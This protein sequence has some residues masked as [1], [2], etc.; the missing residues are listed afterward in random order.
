MERREHGAPARFG[1]LLRQH[2]RA[3]GWTQAALAE[4]SGVSVEAIS[5]QERGR[6]TPRFSTA[7]ALADTLG[8][9]P[10][11]RATFEAAAELPAD[12]E[13]VDVGPART[14]NLP[15][16]STSF[17]G[18]EGEGAEVR[19]LLERHR[20]VTLTGAGGVGK[21]R[22]AL[23]VARGLTG[24][25]PFPDGVW[26][27][28]LAP[29]GDPDLVPQVVA[30]AAGAA[31]DPG[32]PP[33]AALADALRYRRLLLVLDNCEH[34]VEAGAQIVE[35]LLGECPH[36]RLLATSRET[37]GCAGEAVFR[38]PSL[39]LPAAGGAPS[40]EALLDSAAVRLFVDRATAATTS[41]ALTARNAAA[42][43]E[44]CR[45]LDG[46]PLALE[47]AAALV[48]GLPVEE[49]A[50]RLDDRFRLLTGGRRTALG[51]QQTLRALVDWSYDLLAPPEQRLFARLSV[52][53]GA[54]TLEAAEAVCGES[55][56]EEGT[57]SGVL[58]LLLRLV[59]TSFVL[60]DDGSGRAP[61]PDGVARYR[62]LETLREYGRE[63]LV[64]DPAA[65]TSLRDRHLGYHV[66]LVEAAADEP[67]GERQ[68]RALRRL[69]TERDD[70]WAALGW[71]RDRE[72]T[73]VDRR[74]G[75]ALARLTDRLAAPAVSGTLTPLLFELRRLG[76]S[77]YAAVERR[78]LELADTAVLAAGAVLYWVIGDWPAE[79]AVA[80]RLQEIKEARGN[81]GQDAL[82]VARSRL[83]SAR[84]LVFQSSL[85]EALH[86][87]DELSG[88]AIAHGDLELQLDVLLER[89]YTHWHTGDCAAGRQAHA[90]ALTL[91]EHLRP[92][93]HTAVYRAKRMAA[94]RGS[95]LIEHNADANAACRAIHAEALALAREA[96]DGPEET[97]ARLNVADAEW[98]CH[99]YGRALRAYDEALAAPTTAYYLR[100][101]AA[102]VLGRGVVLGSMG[103]YAEATRFLSD[104]LTV[105]R[106]LGDVWFVAYGLVYL[107]TA[108]AGHGDLGAALD[109]TREAATMAERHAVGYPLALAHAHLQWLEEICTPGGA[110]HA[111]RIEAAA[112]EAIRLGLRGPAMH[113]AWV[114]LLHRTFDPAVPDHI[115]QGELVETLRT[116]ALRPPIKGMWELLGLDAIGALA[117]R[118]PSVDRTALV[119]LVEEEIGA[120]AASL[121]ADD[122]RVYL[123]TRR[124]WEVLR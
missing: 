52:F 81:E 61:G 65:A 17:I 76:L 30:A 64:A 105:F 62:L 47:F 108:R 83:G 60:V 99:Q 71:A 107:G 37:L 27:A 29:V 54:F 3:R 34:V 36:L 48:R 101:R 78:L 20:L 113:L 114:R 8:L 63:R 7:A 39:A 44:V 80:Q 25:A 28:E 43:A 10:G 66:G 59:D 124:S 120:K 117:E 79:T 42:V 112:Q 32:R 94:L 40:V 98:G 123:D 119:A 19:R 18:R 49:V 87:L 100:G 86:L 11:E 82:A 67:A 41:F 122:R 106:D 96:R 103:R 51:R 75:D 33:V 93:L 73:G 97:L 38:V 15:H 69:E 5:A 4:R 104:G 116:A 53:A 35:A 90:E 70:V 56:A 89:G 6:E 1:E 77:A 12:K 31:L 109:T 2:R 21:T 58:A 74:L 102:L 16:D 26:L 14:D 46:I 95:G 55:D 45:R 23:E 84:P 22:L 13:A 118:R 85:A 92:R 57:I 88:V 91:L 121:D 72:D 111:A 24:A 50:A 110:G 115:L 9:P 68:A